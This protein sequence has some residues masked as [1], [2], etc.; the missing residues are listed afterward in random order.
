[1]QKQASKCDFGNQI[2]VQLLDRL[3]AGINI[4]NLQRELMQLPKCSFQGA[5]TACI[6]NETVHETDFQ[7]IK[8]STTLLS[9]PI[10]VHTQVHI[11]EH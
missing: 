1:M 2:H 6:I 10:S 8:N 5:I 3:I 9:D 4:P 7:D 11:R